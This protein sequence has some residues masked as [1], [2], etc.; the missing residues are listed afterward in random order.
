[1]LDRPAKRMT[2]PTIR[3]DPRDN[4]LIARIAVPVGAAL[5]KGDLISRS[6]VLPGYKIAAVDLKKGEPI[7]KYN[8]TIGFAAENVPAG[9]LVHSHNIE[10]REFDRDYAFARD[11]SPVEFVP[12]AERA[13][14]PGHRARGRPR[15]HPQLTSAS[16]RP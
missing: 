13:T 3:L 4:V 12:E 16:S 7:R 8:V 10:F 14:L 5:A 1:M 2:G 9:T 15:R 11:Y 6:H